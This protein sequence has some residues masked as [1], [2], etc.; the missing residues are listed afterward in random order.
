MMG[1]VLCTVF[2]FT[3]SALAEGDTDLR[4]EI[5]FLKQRITMLEEKIEKQQEQRGRQAKASEEGVEAGSEGLAKISESFEGLNI[6]I[7]ATYIVQGAADANNVSTAI[8]SKNEEGITDGSYSMCLT[9]EKEF[10]NYG[11]AFLGLETG[12]GAGVEDEL[13]VFS[14]VNRDADDSNNSVGVPEVWYEQYLFDNQFTLRGGK[15]DPTCNVDQN[16][17]AH[18]ECTQ[19]LGRIFR[20]SPTIDFTDNTGGLYMLITPK[21]SEWIDLEAQVLDGYGDWEDTADHVFTTAQI[22]LKPKIQEGLAG[23]YRIYGWYKDI[24]YTKWQDQLKMWEHRYGFGTSI[25]QQLTDIFTVFG[26]YGWCDP[27]VFDP[28][29]TSSSGA[30]YSL[31]HAWSAGFQLNGKPWNREQDHFACAVGMAI[32]SDEYKEYAGTNLRADD[33]GHFE[34]YY[35][36]RLNDHLTLSPDIQVIWNPFGNDYIVNNQRRDETITVIG[37]RGQV[38]F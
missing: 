30:N 29:M 10:D 21:D 16:E 14:N 32:P 25:D 23:N 20:N 13:E 15:I 35:S 27:D 5:E 26:R 17:I 4:K 28:A 24:N 11:K 34:A 2:I 1:F 31:E 7:G 37:C 19:F 8:G 3:E 22:N 33:E 12:D 18:D 38:D 9:F 6:G 36:C